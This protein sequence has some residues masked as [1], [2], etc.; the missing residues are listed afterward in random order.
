MCKKYPYSYLKDI[1]GSFVDNSIIEIQD[2]GQGMD[3]EKFARKAVD[4]GM[5]SADQARAM[6]TK[7]KLFLAGWFF[8]HCSFRRSN[9]RG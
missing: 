8:R 1:A 4:L 5:L 6:S 2:D 3:G 7:E 9:S